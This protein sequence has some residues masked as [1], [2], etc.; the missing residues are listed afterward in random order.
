[1]HHKLAAVDRVESERR[2]R[3]GAVGV[4]C[5]ASGLVCGVLA[6]CNRG[7]PVAPVPAG[8]PP[9]ARVGGVAITQA[10]FDFEVH[11]RAASGRPVGDAQSVLRELIERQAMLQEAARAPWMN[12]PEARRERENQMLA[13]WLDRTL[14]A[15]KRRV[16]VSDDEA[17]ARFKE[18]VAEY[19]RPA[20]VRLAILYRRLSPQD[21]K[22]T[23]EAAT[24]ALQQAR[25]DF[26]KDRAAVTQ[27]GRIPGFGTVA[28]RAS[29]DTIS[30]YRGGDMGWLDA[31]RKDFRGPAAVL[32]AGC[33]LAVGGVSDVLKTDQ[34]LYVV[35]KQDERGAQAIAF[36][37]AA[38]T[39]KRQLIREKEDAVEREFRSNLLARLSVEIDTNRVGRL[40][41]PSEV[42]VPRPLAKRPF[43]EAGLV[44]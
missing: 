13:Q 2:P 17:H 40:T 35:M 41:V 7:T 4:V 27:N 10:D 25:Q 20:M 42:A 29:E 24:A 5:V 21:S 37:E 3:W 38:G 28:A 36:E 9:L 39:L 44:P 26:L 15:E 30:R 23:Q 16:S 22:E 1:M 33:A 8:P 11:R 34:G 43:A 6:G 31:G 14:Q 18:R 32:D 12:E 19:T